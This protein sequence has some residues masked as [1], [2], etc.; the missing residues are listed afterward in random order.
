MPRARRRAEAGEAGP[1]WITARRQTSGRG[2][3]GRSWETGAGNLAATLLT[4]TDRPPAEARRARLRRRPG[5]GRPRPG[6]CARAAGAAEMAQR[7]SDRWPQG[8]GRADRVRSPA[9][10]PA[11]AGDRRR[12]EPRQR[13]PSRPTAP[14]PPSPT[15]CG[16]T[17]PARCRRTP[18]STGSRAPSS[19]G[20]RP[21]SATASSRSAPPGPPAPI[22]AGPSWRAWIGRAW[23]A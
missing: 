19:A 20:C 6:P 18:R 22:S 11:L 16:P 13:A 12:R 23:T 17:S 2:R 7:R 8:L 10:R 21:G 4:T 15:T 14:P 3:R 5:G 9:R 1:L